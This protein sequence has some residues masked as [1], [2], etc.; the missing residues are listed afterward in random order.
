MNRVP[1][2]YEL[3]VKES[4]D[5]GSPGVLANLCFLR[6]RPTH[7]FSTSIFACKFFIEKFCVFSLF[8][9]NSIYISKHF[10]CLLKL[11]S[12][13]NVRPEFQLDSR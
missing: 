7:I 1:G 13:R 6:P 4:L 2:V 9:L 3:T 8:S 10:E 5:T 11:N 12:A